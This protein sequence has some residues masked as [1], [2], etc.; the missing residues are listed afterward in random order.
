[1]KVK[2]AMTKDVVHF[3]IEDGIVKV[4]ETF[5]EKRISGAP[6]LKDGEVIGM[7]TDVD[8]IANLDIYTP[9]IH[10]TSS[11]DFLLILAGLKSDG[12]DKDE[13][14]K[15][16]EVMKKFKVKD[17]MTKRV[18]TINQNETITKAARIMHEKEITRIPVLDDEKNLAGII[19]RQDIIKALTKLET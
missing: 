12:R 6:V 13:I 8:I 2:E 15:E 19:A 3:S 7:I 16:I 18:F 1:M 14:E 5:S 4:L 11:P 10:F 17:F 9:R